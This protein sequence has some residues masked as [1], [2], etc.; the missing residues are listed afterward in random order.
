MF[1]KIRG[2]ME[3]KHFQVM[4]QTAAVS[5]VFRAVFATA[6]GIS[7]VLAIAA[8]GGVLRRVVKRMLCIGY[9]TTALPIFF[10]TVTTRI[11]VFLFVA[12]GIKC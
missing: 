12:S 6:M 11:T 3:K 5:R 1:V 9:C 7:S 8:I 4:A 2:L 10:V